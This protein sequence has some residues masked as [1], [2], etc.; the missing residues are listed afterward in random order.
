MNTKI[1]NATLEDIKFIE[2]CFSLG[3]KEKHFSIKEF[4]ENNNIKNIIQANNPSMQLFIIKNGTD[5]TGFAFCK[6]LDIPKNIFEINML[7]IL[8]NFRRKK[9]AS[10]FIQY[11]EK[12]ISKNYN[13]E[14]FLIVGCNKNNS[15]NAIE[16]FEKLEYKIQKNLKNEKFTFLTKYLKG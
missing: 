12:Y 9:I 14:I 1:E 15:K 10:N 3:F 7:Y 5:N 11:Y 16:L 6:K 4:A 8:S 13:N 2:H